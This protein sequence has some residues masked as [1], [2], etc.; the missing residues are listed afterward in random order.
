MGIESNCS[1][2]ILAI[3]ILWESICEVKDSDFKGAVE[4]L[5]SLSPKGPTNSKVMILPRIKTD[6]PVL[7]L[8][9]V[10]TSF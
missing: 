3:L 5:W 7:S 4:F 10:H 8:K 1:L 6:T 9:N 2:T